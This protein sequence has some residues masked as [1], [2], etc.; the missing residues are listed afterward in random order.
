LQFVHVADLAKMAAELGLRGPAGETFHLA[1]PDAISWAGA[2]TLLAR[3]S[4]RRSPGEERGAS[5]ERYRYPFDISKAQAHG[6]AAT[7]GMRAGLTELVAVSPP[8][9]VVRERWAPA[10]PDAQRLR[11][12]LRWSFPADGRHG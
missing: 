10:S 2:Q 4:G 9:P 8:K 6:V 3:L 5:I 11:P 1:G 12:G 7:M